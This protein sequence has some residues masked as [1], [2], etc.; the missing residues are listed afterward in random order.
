MHNNIKSKSNVMLASNWQE[1]DWKRV[2]MS[3]KKLRYSIFK[4]K[5]SGNIELMCR[6]QRLML[7]S[8]ANI[9][10][11]IRKV[12]SI[13]VEKRT[14]GLDKVLIKTNKARWEMYEDILNTPMCE[15]VNHAKPV[16]RIY[17]P[18]PNGEYRP[19]GIPTI[20]CRVLQNIVK[21]ALEPEWEAIFESSSY[22]F[23]PGRSCH[24]ALARV[25]L[26]LARQK[27]RLWVLDADIK[28]CFDNINH[29][30]LLELIDNFPAKKVIQAWLKAGYCEFPD[31]SV[32]QEDSGTPQGGV[33]SPLLAN[34]ALHGMEKVLNIKT[35]STTG[36]N[37]GNNKYAIIRYADDFIVLSDSKEKCI[38]AKHILIQWLK[39]RGLEFSSEK[40]HVRN[41]FEG[42][43]FLGCHI[44]FYGKQRIKLL[45]KP[46]PEQVSKFRAK[47]RTIF[48]KNKGKAPI[49]L[50]REINPIIRGWANYYLNY[51]SSDTFSSL[52]NYMWHRKWRY[53]KRRHPSKGHK[54]I[55]QR[56]FGQQEGPSKNKWRFYT[57]VGNNKIFMLNFS[58]FKIRRHVIVKN[59]RKPDDR[60]LSSLEYWEKRRAN[61]QFITWSNYESR[62]KLAKRQYHICPICMESLYNEEELHVHHIKPKKKGGKDS[63]KNL[64]ILH[65]FCHRQTHSLSLD[66][67]DI[68]NRT[69]DLRKLMKKKL[70]ISF[71]SEDDTTIDL[72]N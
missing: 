35:V 7:S 28:G 68:Q 8:K 41:V 47:L 9:L 26:S 18:K 45:I 58:D 22:G 40:V 14:P 1:I 42:F 5:K 49:V 16:K 59:S 66:E 6:L 48:L 55:A 63:Y 51:V 21:N 54:W 56:Y 43:K 67:N 44:K 52:D 31:F 64:V 71:F 60:S 62:L 19:L 70:G 32:H 2:N 53:A 38:E 27:K 46:H 29:S 10:L 36:Q 72:I 25:Y 65:E 4:A 69:S 33:I 30:K 23:R 15:W 61:R 39:E 20:K 13:N 34:I 12:S 24:D 11:S 3:I 17:I 50:I 57:E 37:Y